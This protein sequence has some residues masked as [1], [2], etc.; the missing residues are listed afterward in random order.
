[1]PVAGIDIGSR[2]VKVAIV[3]AGTIVQQAVRDPGPDPV[4]EAKRLVAEHKFDR[5]LATG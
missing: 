1:M 4:A 5:V 3:E 2:T